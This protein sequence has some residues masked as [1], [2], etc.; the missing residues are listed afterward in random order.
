MVE[1][2]DAD[3]T[4]SDDDDTVFSGRVIALLAPWATDGPSLKSAARRPADQWGRRESGGASITSIIVTATATPCR[5]RV[6]KM[7]CG[8]S[9]GRTMRQ[10]DPGHTIRQVPA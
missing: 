10:R 2:G 4:A 7:K 1:G 3:R 8:V 9:C 6:G 5:A